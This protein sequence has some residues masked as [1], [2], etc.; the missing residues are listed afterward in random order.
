MRNTVL[1]TGA[2]GFLGKSL[3][4]ALRQNGTHVYA[5]ASKKNQDLEIHSM[6]FLSLHQTKKTMDII[7]PSIV[8]HIGGL[9]NLSREY[10]IYKNCLEINTIGTLNVLESLRENPP[11]KF[12]FISTE[13]VYGDNKV[14]YKEEQEV[15]PPSGYSISKSAAER[16]CILYAKELDFQL[17]ITRIGTMYGPEDRLHRLIPQIILKSLKNEQ[18]N[19]NSGI[20]KRDYVFIKDVVKALIRL[21]DVALID[22]INIINVGGGKSYSLREILDLIVSNTSSMSKVNYGVIPERIGEADEWLMD[23]QK[24]SKLLNWQPKISIDEGIYKTIEYFKK[25]GGMIIK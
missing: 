12:V 6:D 9:V 11:K 7:K 5:T 14:P 1:V 3:I 10:E 22:M 16:L 24:A 18:I 4:R 25:E 8:Y 20:K 21:K 2:S 15:N 23:I 19:L 13:E 17:I